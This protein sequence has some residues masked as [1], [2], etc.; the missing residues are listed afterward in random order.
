ML[1]SDDLTL[2]V[3]SAAL[4]SFSEAAREVDL[5]PGQV[6]AAIGR[7]ERALGIRVF[8]RSTR[9]LRLTAEGERYLPHA[10]AAVASL[11]AGAEQ[12]QAAD[13]ELSGALQVAV[14]SDLG[15]QVLLPWLID[16]RR[17][18][19]RLQLRLFVSDRLTDVFR[20]PVD[21]A[22][23]YSAPGDAS[24]VALPLAPTN[25]R[26]LVASP[27]YLARRGR[28]RTLE[29]LVRHDCLSFA[30]SGRIQERWTFF[31][32][33]ERRVVTVRSLVQCDDGEVAAR[34]AMAGEGIAY[35]SWLDVGERVR[36]GRLVQLLPRFAGEPAPLHLVCPHRGQYSPAVRQLHRLLQQ[37][38]AALV[39]TQP[40]SARRGLR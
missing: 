4:G 34:L 12:L 5:L 9:S 16:F 24:V 17:Q 8:A 19:P 31:D 36:D 11:R 18:H 13:G 35:K 10:Q 32:R 7:L 37:R 23:R 1:R 21:V 33:G 20:E 2:F 26:V 30:L 22:V 27:A 40:G 14:P 39:A 28:P 15:R 25:R 3:R 29:D 6:S 38:L